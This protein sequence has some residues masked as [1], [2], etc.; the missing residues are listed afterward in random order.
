MDET[1]VADTWLANTLT[2]DAQL[3]GEVNGVYSSEAPQGAP[4]PYVIFEWMGGTDVTFVN[5]IRVWHSGVWV[6]KAVD[7]TTTFAD[8]QTAAERLEALLHRQSGNN[9]GGT[10]FTATREAPFR[11]AYSD[12]SGKSYR[13]LGGR[14]RIEV[15]AT[16]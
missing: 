12:D 6:V 13:E 3:M 15:Q 11:S 2:N 4:M 8:L 9:S 14:F 1:L 7:E 5:G 10:V 16:P